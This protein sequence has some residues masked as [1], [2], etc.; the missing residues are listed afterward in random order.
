MN[1]VHLKSLLSLRMDGVIILPAMPA[2]YD[3]QILMLDFVK[4]ISKAKH[5][6]FEDEA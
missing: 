3:K 6:T 4:V 2:F 5:L 1:A